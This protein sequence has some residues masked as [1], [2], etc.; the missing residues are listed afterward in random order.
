MRWVAKAGMT[1]TQ[2]EYNSGTWS[3][4]WSFQYTKMKELTQ[5]QPYQHINHLPGN[6]LLTVKSTL[7]KQ[8]KDLR[9]R[10]GV[11]HF[12][13]MPEHYKTVS[14][15]DERIAPPMSEAM[16]RVTKEMVEKETEK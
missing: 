10:H 16:T 11:K 1:E 9:D 4:L 5:I 7:F 6:Y 13:F 12:D 3:L 14:E 2:D 8:F 15:F